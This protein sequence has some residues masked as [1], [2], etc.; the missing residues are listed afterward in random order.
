MDVPWR[1]IEEIAG[2]VDR[3]RIRLDLVLD[4]AVEYVGE[5]RT[6]MG[7][8]CPSRTRLWRSGRDRDADYT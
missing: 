5:H 3:R 2:L 1:F 6:R 8:P 7:V 4:L